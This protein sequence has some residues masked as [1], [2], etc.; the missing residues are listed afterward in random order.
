M[1]K[2]DVEGI[3]KE[4]DGI[5]ISVSESNYAQQRQ[6]MI[7]QKQDKERINILENRLSKIETLLKQ[8]IQKG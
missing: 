6:K 8:L 5:L 2:T 7:E 1:H 3:M 4:A